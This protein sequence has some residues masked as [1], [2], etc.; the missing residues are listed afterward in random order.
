MLRNACGLLARIIRFRGQA[1]QAP[2]PSRVI[3]DWRRSEQGHPRSSQIGVGFS[4]S[5]NRLAWVLRPLG[6]NPMS[7]ITS[8][9][10]PPHSS[11]L[12]PDWRRLQRLG[13]DWLRVARYACVISQSQLF[14]LFCRS[15][16]A[17]ALLAKFSKIVA[18]GTL[19]C[20]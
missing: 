4:E 8:T 7:R 3:P 15:L 5:G 6:D 10:S 16:V 11:H 12:I 1:I 19:G 13:S 18:F 2:T 20:Y 14:G 9:P 17:S